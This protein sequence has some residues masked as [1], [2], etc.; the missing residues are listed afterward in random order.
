MAILARIKKEQA[1]EAKKAKKIE[2]ETESKNA[3]KEA[4]AAR[5]QEVSHSPRTMQNASWRLLFDDCL[6]SE[7]TLELIGSSAAHQN[8]ETHEALNWHG[9]VIG[10]GSPNIQRNII[11]ERIFGLPKD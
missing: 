3:E 11:G 8:Y 9:T 7:L 6:R 10:G 1:E 4:A 5:V 2:S